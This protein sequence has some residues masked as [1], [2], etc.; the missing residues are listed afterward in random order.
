MM[1]A[2][3]GLQSRAYLRTKVTPSLHLTYSKMWESGLLPLGAWDRLRYVI[4]AIPGP[5]I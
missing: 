4:V 2:Y 5:S 1:V 3:N